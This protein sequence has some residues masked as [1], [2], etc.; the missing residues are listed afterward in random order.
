ME[1]AFQQYVRQHVGGGGRKHSIF[2]S[3]AQLLTGWFLDEPF[4][5]STS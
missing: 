5:V 2:E 4:K 3:E 1:L